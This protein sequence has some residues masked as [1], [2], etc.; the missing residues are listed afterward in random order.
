MLRKIQQTLLLLLLL[1]GSGGGLFLYKQ[2][3]SLEQKLQREADE[4]HRQLDEEKKHTE[5]L[6]QVVSRLET[7]QRVADIMVTDQPQSA[8]TPQTTLLFVE[9]GKDGQ[10]LPPKTFTIDGKRGHIDA[11]V[12]KFDGKFV[13]QNDPLKGHSVALFTRLYSDQTDPAHGYQIDDPGH[14]PAVY[15]GAAQE[16]S[17][18][19][20]G[21]WQNFWRLA[22]D[23]NYRKEM[24]V[25]IAQGE[26][27]WTDFEKGW[28][29]RVTLESNGGLNI[30]NS[31]IPGI[32]EQ[33]M[34]ARHSTSAP[35]TQQ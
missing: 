7:E 24:G 27:V 33:A 18:F 34:H 2:H 31:R 10:A 35:A 19:E 30:V 5:A 15:R 16:V 25:R 26:G 6:K 20:Q 1:V 11:L 17:S 13:E 29:Y 28:I 8:G 3:N 4:A 22:E 9:Y 21:L 12:V 14:I 23:P 32:Y